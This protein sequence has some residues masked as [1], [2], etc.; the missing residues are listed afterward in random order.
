MSGAKPG[1]LTEEADAKERGRGL[2]A[3]YRPVCAR[4]GLAVAFSTWP[5]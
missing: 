4:A 1:T 2:Q 3:T 5:V